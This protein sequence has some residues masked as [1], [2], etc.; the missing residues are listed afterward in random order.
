M[1]LRAVATT[2][3]LLILALLGAGCTPQSS[4]DSPCSKVGT[5][6]TGNGNAISLEYASIIG[7]N[8]VENQGAQETS[9]IEPGSAPNA[10]GLC[11]DV[12]G[13]RTPNHVTTWYISADATLNKAG[14]ANPDVVIL[15]RNCGGGQ[16]P[17][18]RE[19][20]G[21][22]ACIYGNDVTIKCAGGATT[23]DLFADRSTSLS[24]YFANNGGLP[25]QYYVI[26]EVSDAVNANTDRRAFS[27]NFY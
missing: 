12:A 8:G 27:A 3:P 7:S 5:L 26:V 15:Q 21:Y 19:D 22:A 17:E 24:N 6:G 4:D 11:W 10:L 25:K 16:T 23:A 9:S 18:C 20:T 1:T 14:T 2:L 13:G